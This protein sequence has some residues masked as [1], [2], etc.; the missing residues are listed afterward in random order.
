MRVS[1]EVWV[2]VV[3]C[4][5]V[6]VMRCVWVW[7][8]GPDAHTTGSAHTCSN[9]MHMQHWRRKRHATSPHDI[10][11]G[12]ESKGVKE[13]AE[14]AKIHAKIVKNREGAAEICCVGDNST[15]CMG[16]ACT[17]MHYIRHCGG[18]RIASNTS[19]SGHEWREG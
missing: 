7:V 8:S 11:T 16:M 2:R 12:N 5:W 3:R 6:W 19:E 1:H 10:P 17:Y 18:T 13:L 4:V 9:S 15:T 14:K